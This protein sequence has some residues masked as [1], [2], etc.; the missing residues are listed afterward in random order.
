ML[1]KTATAGRQPVQLFDD[2]SDY[3][4]FV[5]VE[6]A[7]KSDNDRKRSPE[8]HV[9]TGTP[10]YVRQ[11]RHDKCRCSAFRTLCKHKGLNMS[12]RDVQIVMKD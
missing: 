3:E 6:S 2:M 9:K 12:C 11:E 4:A 8:D 7:L 10:V 1:Q 5:S